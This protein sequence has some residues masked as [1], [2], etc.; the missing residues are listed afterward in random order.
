MNLPE[1]LTDVALLPSLSFPFPLQHPSLSGF[2][3]LRQKPLV[4]NR[5]W[6]LIKTRRDSQERE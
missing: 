2:P 3:E 5:K 4:R 6:L 1:I